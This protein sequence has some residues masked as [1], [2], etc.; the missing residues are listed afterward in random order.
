MN[1]GL[2]RNMR[3]WP[4]VSLVTWM[5]NASAELIWVGDSALPVSRAF[6]RR[7]KNASYITSPR[8]A[9]V[10]YLAAELRD[11][12]LAAIAIRSLGFVLYCLGIDRTIFVGNFPVSTSHWDRLQECEIPRISETL[13]TDNPDYFI[14]VRNIL[15]HRHPGLAMALKDAGF[16]AF[17][18]RVI[19]EFDFTRAVEK[20]YS[21]MQKDLNLFSKSKL[22]S[23][24]KSRLSKDEIGRIQSLYNKIYLQKHSLL[25]AQYS[26]EFFNDLVN[27]DVMQCLLVVNPQHDILAFALLFE[28][29]G[30][31]T[32]PALGYD[33]DSETVGTYRLLF[34]AIY[35]HA[36]ERGILLNYSSGAGDFKRKRG[37]T[38]HLEYTYL[39]APVRHSRFLNRL[40]QS[41][42]IKLQSIQAE[43]L[44]SYG[45]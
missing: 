29:A 26:F 33:C 1:D 2:N 18:A 3:I 5:T 19:Y 27:A 25:N 14:G 17:P 35:T 36:K 40:L 31:L 38:P 41:M 44:I 8:S 9:W 11:Q 22:T 45:A 16:H 39:R 24:V 15:P 43:T 42:S 30:T 10:D 4:R 32:I 34:A 6:A 28:Q 20:K 13:S 7:D 12:P 37:G 21:H 23:I